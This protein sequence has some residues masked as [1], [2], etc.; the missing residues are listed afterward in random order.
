VVNVAIFLQTGEKYFCGMGRLCAMTR[1][2]RQETLM[3]QTA[4]EKKVSGA[5]RQIRLSCH[6]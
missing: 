2:Q 6:A 5:A 4:L 1:R 3:G